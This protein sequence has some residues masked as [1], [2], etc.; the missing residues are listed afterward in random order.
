MAFMIA[1]T[2]TIAAS[3]ILPVT[4]WCE[5]GIVGMNYDR[6]AGCSSHFVRV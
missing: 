4:S 5:M 3:T 1:S 2:T 6:A